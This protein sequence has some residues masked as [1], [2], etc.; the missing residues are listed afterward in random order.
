MKHCHP[1]PQNPRLA[2]WIFATF[3]WCCLLRRLRH[4]ATCAQDL[5]G[6]V[7]LCCMLW[8]VEAREEFQK[9]N[10]DAAF[11]SWEALLQ[12]NGSNNLYTFGTHWVSR[13]LTNVLQKTF[14]PHPVPFWIRIC[15][16]NNLLSTNS[17]FF[18][19][20]ISQTYSWLS[21]NQETISY[22]TN[23]NKKPKTSKSKQTC[24]PKPSKTIQDLQTFH[25]LHSS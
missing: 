11:Y 25:L 5:L 20:G 22:S 19:R 9:G 13:M 8:H 1:F 23:S 3:G 18:T 10:Q 21:Q 15:H 14:C 6:L 24:N 7:A 17:S 12:Q 2:T 4:Q 16:A